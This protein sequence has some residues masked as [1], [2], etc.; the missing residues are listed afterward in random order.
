MGLDPK[1]ASL[2]GFAAKSGKLL[3]GAYSVEQGISQKKAKL[4]LTASD[5]NPKRIE[6]LSMWCRDM[7]IPILCIG[8]KTDYGALLRKP[9]LGL[10]ALTDEHM[11]SGVINAAETNR[12]TGD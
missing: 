10:L 3:L 8:T 6:K 11:V 1:I 4:V 5:M 7:E 9:P 2:I 12:G